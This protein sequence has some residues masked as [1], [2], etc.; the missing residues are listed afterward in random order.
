[1]Y[2]QGLPTS[3]CPVVLLLQGMGGQKLA[4]FHPACSRRSENHTSKHTARELGASLCCSGGSAVQ[5]VNGAPLSSTSPSKGASDSHHTDV[6]MNAS[7]A[8]AK[9]GGYDEPLWAHLKASCSELGVLHQK[10]G[11]VCGPLS[12]PLAGKFVQNGTWKP[13]SVLIFL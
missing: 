5:C 4:H 10:H 12:K 11:K 1:M 3:V 9:L 8:F 6:S 2:Q 7:Q 13:A